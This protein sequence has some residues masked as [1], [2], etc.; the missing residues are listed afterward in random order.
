MA[1]LSSINHFVVVMLENRSFDHMLGFLYASS[2][3]Q[4]PLGQPFEGLAGNESNPDGKGGAVK[5]FQIKPTDPHPY[6]MPGADPGEGYLNTN[7][8]LFGTEQAPNP[9]TVPANQ[10]FV[11][12]FAST[13][14]WESKQP[15][16]VVAGTTPGQIMGVYPPSMLPI[17]SGL[18]AGYAVCDHWYGSA[19]T[20]TFPN[21]AFVA[22]ATSQGF[23]QDKSCKVY[24]APSIYT[25]LGKN[26]KTWAIYGYS[27][28]P[29]SRGSV[30]DISAAPPGNFGQ[31]A[32]FQ[33]AAAAGTLANYVFLEP[34]WGSA[35]SSQHP[36]DDVSK[37]EQFLHDV[38]YTV[39]NSP[40]WP[41]T[42]LV[43]TYDEHGGLYDHVA[44]PNN[45]VAPDNSAGELGF[46][47]QRFG[48]RVP[49]VLVN[50]FIPAGTVCRAAGATPFDHTSILATV[51][52]RFGLPALTKRDAAAPDFGGVLSLAKARTDDPLAGVTVPTSGTPPKLGPGPNHLEQALADS[53]EL[54]P[55]SDALKAGYHHEMP[56]FKS[57]KEAVA[58]ATKRYAA[59]DA[60]L[61]A[62]PAKRGVPKGKPLSGAPSKPKRRSGRGRA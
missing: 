8:Q 11:T 56:K 41:Q 39:R 36:N 29:L 53:A 32:D 46:D 57:G 48:P 13:L 21:R 7:W 1:S 16:R 30:S 3:N 34:S 27:A 54:L 12:N 61:G 58:Y 52:K 37:G 47:F 22:M 2:G 14:A 31:F 28:P 25:L 9:V 44:P 60:K 20:E 4:S 42:V 18:A 40:L 62:K 38:Y 43:I 5:V 17:L 6:F 50:P 49:T 24:T 35:G 19:P 55:V 59:L 51:E 26:G 10:G 33:K 15:G 45:A 23:V